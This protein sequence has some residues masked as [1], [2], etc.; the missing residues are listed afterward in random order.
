MRWM[1]GAAAAAALLVVAMVA[2]VGSA[3]VG[4]EGP[5]SGHTFSDGRVVTVLDG[6]VACYL[7]DVGGGRWVLVDA[8]MAP[9]GG[10]IRGAL[11][12][13][14]GTLDDVDLILLTHGHSDHVG[15]APAMGE[16]P[17]RALAAELP[18]LEGM[19]GYGGPLPGLMGAVDTGIR[20]GT[21]LVDG[22]HVAVGDTVIEVF[23]VPGHTAG[24]AVFLAHGVLFVGDSAS[25]RSGGELE[26]APWVFSDDVQTNRASLGV[27]GKRLQPRA[28]D[29]AWIAP[30][31]TTPTEGLSPLLELGL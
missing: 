14:G 5:Q 23:A 11:A 2:L 6:Y 3:F 13:R 24:S 15:G 30:G 26:P 19:Q 21:P 1:K 29:V 31:H 16:T 25:A 8:C 4:I 17:V 10:A 28:G 12:E 18:H 9:D 22:E 20:V 27:L 7:V